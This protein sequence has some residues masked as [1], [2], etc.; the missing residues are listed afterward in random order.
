MTVVRWALLALVT[1]S[2]AAP[3]RAQT[4]A[5][6]VS[7]AATAVAV[8]IYRDDLA[9]VTETREIDLPAGPVKLVIRGVAETLLPQSAIVTGAQRAL[10]ESNFTFDRL[11]PASLLER[12]VGKAVTL[13]RTNPRTGVVTRTPATIVAA[14]EGVVLQT[15]DGSEALYCSELPERL[16]FD[17]LPAGLVSEPELSVQLAAGN[18]GPR[19]LT[20]SY[21]A[22]GFTWSADYVASL[23]ERSDR[24]HLDGWI[25]LRNATGTRF[26]QAQVQVVAGRLNLVAAEDRGSASAEPLDP[27]KADSFVDARQEDVRRQ[28]EQ[29]VA[30]LKSCYAIEPRTFPDG[31]VLKADVMPFLATRGAALEEVV[32][33]GSRR[34]ASREQLGDYQLYRLPTATDLEA[35]Q[36][37]QVA[38]LGK[39]A[40]RIERFYGFRL[41]D[42]DATPD[43][44]FVIP[45]V[46][47]RWDNTERAGLGEP[48]PSGRVRVF[49]PYGKSEVF[50]GEADVGDRPVGLPTEI[51]IGRALDVALDVQ[52]H[53]EPVGLRAAGGRWRVTAEY[54]ITNGKSAPV[55]MEIRHGVEPPW[56]SAR[57]RKS[58]LRSTSKNG[59]FAWRFSV[60]A[61]G[62]TVLTYELSAVDGR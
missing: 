7:P 46:Y 39:Q 2:L 36:T 15:Q 48:L 30:L 41:A 37:K 3:V 19:T 21:L 18:A 43:D 51:E 40:V 57:V 56:T 29:D 38:F 35:R 16:E 27:D 1:G 13:T 5:T 4:P 12:S 33:T 59:D 53:D 24:M 49:E 22:H 47:L 52:T 50:A 32:V 26:T 62:T 61:G 20:V 11:T 54:R 58:S 60:P 31:R 8:T 17:G 10:A 44:P 25:T 28:A 14:G 45:G 9:L 23:N 34:L 6:V 42:F 55:S